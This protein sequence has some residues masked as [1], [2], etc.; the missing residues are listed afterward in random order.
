[1]QEFGTGAQDRASAYG[2]QTQAA[3]QDLAGVDRFALARERMDEVQVQRRDVGCLCG[4][5]C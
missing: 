1:M 4:I 5:C 2:A 3:A